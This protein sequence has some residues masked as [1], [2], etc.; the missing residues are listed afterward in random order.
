MKTTYKKASVVKN[1]YKS[2]VNL[3]L[4]RKEY[5]LNFTALTLSY[6]PFASQAALR[7]KLHTYVPD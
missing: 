4:P 7:M 6:L 1:D 2:R 3:G 5:Y